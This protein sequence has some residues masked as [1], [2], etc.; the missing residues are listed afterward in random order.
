MAVYDDFDG[1]YFTTQSLR[2]SHGIRSPKTEIIVVDQRPQTS[3]G[4]M[5]RAHCGT[6]GAKYI[7]MPEPL[8]TSP[9]RNRVIQEA[10]GEFVLCLDSHVI[11]WP[12]AI[13]YLKACIETGK[14]AD[15][16]YHGPMIYDN[17]GAFATHF[18]VRWR[19]EMLGTWG[20]AWRCG[21]SNLGLRFSCIDHAPTEPNKLSYVALEDGK[22]PVTFCPMC[23]KRLPEIAWAGHESKLHQADYKLML[24]DPEPF[25]IPA[26][27]LGLFLTKKDS[28]LGFVENSVGFGGE[29]VNIHDLYRLSGRK[30]YCLP[31]LKWVHKFGRPN[32]V[33]YPLHRYHKVRNYVLW[34]NRM[35]QPLDSI[36]QHFVTEPRRM[37]QHE[38][39]YLVSD[40]IK[41]VDPP[42]GWA[43]CGD[44]AKQP[45]PAFKSIQEAFDFV[46]QKPRD[47]DQH[48]H[49]LEEYAS[50]CQHVT[51]IS[52]R[53]ESI[54][55]LLASSAKTV[56]SYNPEIEPV[57]DYCLAQHADSSRWTG[58]PST[59]KEIE[60]TEL[61]FL[62]TRHT[63]S[64]VYQELVTFAPKISKYIILHNTKIF[65]EKGEDGQRGILAAVRDFLRKNPQWSVIFHTNEQYGLTIL[66][67]LDSEKPKLPSLIDRGVNFTKALAEHVA[68][69]ASKVE[70]PI[71]EARL[72]RCT[73]CPHRTNE[74]CSVCGCGL[75]L[76]SSWQTSE[77]PLGYWPK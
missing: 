73:I 44:V 21:C 1:V 39:D 40:P 46:V 37:K 64:Q 28:W 29:E 24:N 23:Q 63:Y 25:E 13:D 6:I 77:C 33:T 27:G 4:K 11:L 54:V 22:T 58:D 36:Y 3:H 48:L 47:M 65:A 55:A 15:H 50:K 34:A 41:H 12:G 59:V 71:M 57:S 72:D 76:K 66:T 70:L 35:G 31:S 69:G 42:T 43:G 67:Q 30:T 2:I 5:T 26:Q 14:L 7:E 52:I 62:N 17:L 20:L 68:T 8:G 45:S 60:P 32:G 9:S 75:V 16:L 38:W 19:M 74:S 10:S 61:L 56:R 18:N 53:R 51:D 49:T